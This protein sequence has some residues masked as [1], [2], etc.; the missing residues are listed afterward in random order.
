[1]TAVVDPELCTG[2]ETCVD[3]C[4]AVAIR[5]EEGKAEVDPGLCVDCGTCVDECPSGAIHLE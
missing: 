5:M 3:V 1:M 4:P 2:C